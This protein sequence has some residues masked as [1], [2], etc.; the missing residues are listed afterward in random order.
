MG[1]THERYTTNVPYSPNRDAEKVY[2]NRTIANADP[3][4][5]W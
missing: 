5:D 3:Q 2:R 1:L 4:A